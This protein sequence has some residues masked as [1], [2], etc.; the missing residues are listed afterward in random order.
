MEE[1]FRFLAPLF[2]LP[3][4]GRQLRQTLNKAEQA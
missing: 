1:L 2:G 3:F 4:S